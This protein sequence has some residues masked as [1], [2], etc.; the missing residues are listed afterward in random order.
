M[1]NQ[2]NKRGPQQVGRIPR[3]GD[4]RERRNS[5]AVAAAYLQDG[6]GLERA[7]DGKLQV[8]LDVVASA[9]SV[10]ELQARIEKLEAVIKAAGTVI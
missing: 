6:V 8:D 7:T 9:E 4:P 10:A 1:A 2:L 3:A 5:Q